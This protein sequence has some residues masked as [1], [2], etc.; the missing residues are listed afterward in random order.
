MSWNDDF[1]DFVGFMTDGTGE[2]DD[3]EC[4]VFGDEDEEKKNDG[5]EG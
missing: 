5:S 1:M 2:L 3:D 4:V